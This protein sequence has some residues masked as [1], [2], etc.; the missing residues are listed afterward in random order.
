MVKELRILTAADPDPYPDSVK[1]PEHPTRK[2]GEENGIGVCLGRPKT[3][4]TPKKARK[5]L[6]R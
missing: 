5:S 6:F 4:G 3:P 2:A 1:I